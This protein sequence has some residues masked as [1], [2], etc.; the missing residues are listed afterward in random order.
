MP[1][2]DP[3]D[4]DSRRRFALVDRTAAF[5]GI[6]RLATV[7]DVEPARRRLAFDELF[8]LQLALVLRRQRLHEDA[9][10]IAHVTA[11]DG[12]SDPGRPVRRSAALPTDAAPRSGRSADLAADLGVAA[13]DAP[14]AAGRRRLGQDGRRGGRAARRGRGRPPG[15][16]HGADRGARR[17]ALPR[18]PAPARSASASPDPD[19]LSGIARSG[20]PCS[21]AA[22]ERPSGPPSTHG[23]AA[24]DVDLLVGTHALLTE[25]V[26]FPS[27]GVVVIDEQHRFGVEQRAALREKGRGEDGGDGI[28]TCSS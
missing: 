14:L 21:P 17:A 10:G 5:S 25:D 7:D 20:S 18:G 19:T 23:L 13:A 3:L 11:P 8:R 9:R 28:P 24:G 27:L 15:C 16:A 6:H 1:F 26:V 4:L 12:R 22:P 2:A